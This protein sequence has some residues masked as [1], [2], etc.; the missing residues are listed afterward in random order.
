MEQSLGP[1]LKKGVPVILQAEWQENSDSPC[2]TGTSISVM[3]KE[4]PQYD[5]STV[6]PVFP[7][8]KGLYAYSKPSL[9]KRGITVR[10]WLRTRPEKVI[11]VVTHSGFLRVGVSYRRYEN[12]DFRVFDFAEG[13]TANGGRLVE[14]ELTE[15]KGGGLGKSPKGVFEKFHHTD[16]AHIPDVAKEDHEA[17]E[18]VPA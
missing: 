2:D 6:D 3:K 13:E 17:A 1:Q 14:W 11:A 10:E 8:K 5:W 4:W 12:A 15:S 7:A 16:D 18:E 9:I